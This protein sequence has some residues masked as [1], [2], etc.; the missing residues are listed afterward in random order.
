MLASEDSCVKLEAEKWLPSSFLWFLGQWLPEQ[1]DVRFWFMDH[2]MDPSLTLL[3]TKIPPFRFRPQMSFRDQLGY[4]L[5]QHDMPVL[6]LLVVVFVRIVNLFVRH[7]HS[8]WGPSAPHHQP[9]NNPMCG[10]NCCF[11]TCTQVSQEAGKMVW[12]S[13]HLKEFSTVCCDTH[14]QKL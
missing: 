4:V 8:A 10:S 3:N 9:P 6:E 12:Y 7:D 2:I 14:S 13:H 5:G 11:L 1:Q